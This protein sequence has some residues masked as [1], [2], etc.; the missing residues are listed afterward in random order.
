MPANVRSKHPTPGIWQILLIFVG[1][2][3]IAVFV[4]LYS[5]I[6]MPLPP[7]VGVVVAEDPVTV[8][9][10]Q[11][12]SPSVTVVT[13]DRSMATDAALGYGRYSLEALASLA[14]IEKEPALYPL[15]VQK[16]LGLP[17][18]WVVWETGS[19]E[20]TDSDE[21]VSTAMSPVMMDV[22]LRKRKSTIP[23]PM[24]I[25]LVWYFRGI[26][27]TDVTHIR[28]PLPVVADEEQLPDGSRIWV[29]DPQKFDDLLTSELEQSA[30]RNE[31]LTVS[32]YNT[33]A[34]PGLASH[35]ARLLG[36]LGVHVVE[37]DGT[38]STID[39]CLLTGSQEALASLT[40][41]IIQEY[42][43]CDAGVTWEKDRTDLQLRV[44]T[45]YARIF[46]TPQR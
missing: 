35:A 42:F 8:H 14:E 36:H 37:V 27:V 2:V 18:Q 19:D 40:A 17:V 16:A 24:Q 43:A 45:E 39:T 7:V 23:L 12:D 34:I 13:L 41:G 32:V 3:T 33:T 10:L 5:V 46:E 1:T 25:R 22:I 44:G 6:T 31:R 9:L 30:V 11:T 29:F 38:E 28:A 15:T 20:N 21:V 4:W 26:D